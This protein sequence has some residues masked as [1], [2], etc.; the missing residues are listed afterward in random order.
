MNTRDKLERLREFR[1]RTLE[2]GGP[3]R[4]KRQH[5]RGKL[6]ARERLDV[7]LDPGSFVELDR[8]EMYAVT[9]RAPTS[10]R[11]VASSSDRTSSCRG[12]SASK[13]SYTIPALVP[14]TDVR[15]R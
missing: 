13:S 5:D 1:L 9:V 3:E 8:F 15:A 7:L 12:M 14:S 4:L 10:F 2:G 6:G 11:S